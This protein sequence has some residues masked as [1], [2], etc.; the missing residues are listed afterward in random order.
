MTSLS[1]EGD[2]VTRPAAR[3]LFDEVFAIDT[4]PKKKEEEPPA[5]TFDQAAL[6]AAAAA[7]REEGRREGIAEGRRQAE[8]ETEERVAQSAAALVKATGELAASRASQE[9]R[10][11]EEAV[12]IGLAAARKLCSALIARE[13]MAE[14]E[15]LIRDAL[16]WAAD[17]PHLVARVDPETAEILRERIDALASQ[18]GFQGRVVVLP[19]P[20]VGPGDGRIDWADG[21]AVRDGKKIE[22]GITEAVERFLATRRPE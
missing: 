16:G 9:K 1:T 18:T 14:I 12:T 11:A 4:A 19:D 22:A 15:A 6:D 17:A 21:G 7:A 3:Y 20:E 8:L 5:P 10:D 13:P 2:I